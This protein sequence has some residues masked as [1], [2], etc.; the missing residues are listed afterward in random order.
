MHGTTP[1]KS[2]VLEVMNDE[3]RPTMVQTETPTVPNSKPEVKY[4]FL[5]DSEMEDMIAAQTSCTT[6][7]M[8]TK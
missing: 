6:E 1:L 3:M 7:K 8:V 4:V 2:E 5:S